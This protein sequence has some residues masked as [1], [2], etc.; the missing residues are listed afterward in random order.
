MYLY[1]QFSKPS[2]VHHL[3]TPKYQ[4][5]FSINIW[6]IFSI[7]KKK[8]KKKKKCVRL[9]GGLAQFGTSTKST[10]CWLRTVFVKVTHNRKHYETYKVKVLAAQLHP[11]LCNP[12]ELDCSLPASV[13]GILQARILGW[14]AIPFSRGSSWPKDQT[15]IFCI[16]GILLTISTTREALIPHKQYTKKYIFI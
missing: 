4:Q 11:T 5:E 7:T 9:F 1:F 6:N 13:H 8:L 12:K 16:W 10:E 14:V 15:Q 3:L 2:S